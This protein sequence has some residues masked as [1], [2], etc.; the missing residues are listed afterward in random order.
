MNR[1]IFYSVLKQNPLYFSY[2]YQFLIV[3]L[4][5]LLSCFFFACRTKMIFFFVSKVASIQHILYVPKMRKNYLLRKKKTIWNCYFFSS[6]E[7]INKKKTK[8]IEMRF[9]RFGFNALVFICFSS[10]SCWSSSVQRV[11][12]C[13]RIFFSFS[14][15]QTKHVVK[16]MRNVLMLL[17]LLL[18]FFFL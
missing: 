11:S 3:H 16:Q 5:R 4:N 7:M 13:H 9:V 2:E 1:F 12:L 15:D 17:L 18:Y 14:L 6:Q 8:Y 10:I